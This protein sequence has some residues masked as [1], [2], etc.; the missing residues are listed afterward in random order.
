METK[1]ELKEPAISY[2]LMESFDTNRL[3][4]LV[5]EGVQFPVFSSLLKKISFSI[6]EWASF[7]H[8]SERTMHRYQKENKTFDVVSSERIIQITILYE[9]GITVF[10]NK[11]NFDTWLVSK[12]LALGSKPKE[13]LDTVF[14]IELINNE[15]S[16]I[17]HGIFA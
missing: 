9:Y 4:Q 16:R 11:E 3:I 8:L 14:G 7:L 15:L 13:L 17:E 10:G 1:K 6:S 12:N 5:R 2:E